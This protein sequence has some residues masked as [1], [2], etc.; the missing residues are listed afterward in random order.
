[1]QTVQRGCCCGSACCAKMMFAWGNKSGKTFSEK[2]TNTLFHDKWI[3]GLK[4]MVQCHKDVY[5]NSILRLEFAYL[6]FNKFIVN[7]II[8]ELIKI[9]LILTWFS[10]TESTCNESF[11]YHQ[12]FISKNF[13]SAF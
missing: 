8:S 3:K 4:W 9:G 12:N 13:Q 11:N 5:Q 6:L 7:R 2:S 10:V 1:M